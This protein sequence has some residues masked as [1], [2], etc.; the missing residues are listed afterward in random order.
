MYGGIKE[1][2]DRRQPLEGKV[3]LVFTD[4]AKAASLWSLCPRAM[5]D[6]MLQHNQ[7]LRSLLTKHRGYEAIFLREKLVREGSFFM[8]FGSSL[9]A[10]A[11]CSKVQQSLL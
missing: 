3:V 7:V 6:T 10:L 8:V 2:A 5:H 4:I 1:G 11:W 9:D